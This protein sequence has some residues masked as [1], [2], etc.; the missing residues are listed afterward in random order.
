MQYDNLAVGEGGERGGD[1]PKRWWLVLRAR[2]VHQVVV[3]PGIL[4]A[5]PG[6]DWDTEQ[7]EVILHAEDLGHAAEQ[8]GLQVGAMDGEAGDARRFGRP[9]A[10]LDALAI[11][12]EALGSGAVDAVA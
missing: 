3:V 6:A 1:Q 11:P 12:R 5:V 10:D 8:V 4:V 7:D 2:L 9:E